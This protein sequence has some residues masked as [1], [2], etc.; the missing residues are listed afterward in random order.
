M[1][2][3]TPDL[4]DVSSRGIAPCALRVE[5]YGS[6]EIAQGSLGIG[7]A[8]VNIAAIEVGGGAAAVETD[9][10]VAIRQRAIEILFGPPPSASAAQGSRAVLCGRF[11]IIDH[12][13]ACHD[14]F[15]GLG[16]LAGKLAA[17]EIALVLGDAEAEKAVEAAR[18]ARSTRKRIFPPAVAADGSLRLRLPTLADGRRAMFLEAGTDA[19]E[20]GGEAG[21]RSTQSVG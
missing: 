21:P 18:A 12:A 1:V 3:V 11:R 13:V 10:F 19:G 7:F 4:V 6:V 5:T 17:V 16:E 8:Q 20:T 9:R 2:E 14:A 15:I